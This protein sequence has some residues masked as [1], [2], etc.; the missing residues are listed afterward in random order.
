[1][2]VVKNMNYLIKTKGL[3]VTSSSGVFSSKPYELDFLLNINDK[4]LCLQVIR[5]SLLDDRLKERNENYRY[6]RTCEIISI[7]EANNKNNSELNDTELSKLMADA[8]TLNCVPQNITQY[9]TND[10]KVKALKKA[11]QMSKMRAKRKVNNQDFNE[12]N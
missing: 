6:F 3:F 5:K 1:M 11:L 9:T 7:S 4:N 8:I 2:E 12:L 10:Q